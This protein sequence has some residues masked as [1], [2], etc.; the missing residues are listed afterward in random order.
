MSRYDD[1]TDDVIELLD[2]VREEWF[3]ELRSAKIKVMFDTKKRTSGGKVV[4]ARIQKTNDL[5]K[6]L[7]KEEVMSDFGYDYFL[8]LDKM[9][10]T[11]GTT[12]EDKKKILQHELLHTSVDMEKDNSYVV[13][14][15]EVETFYDEIDRCKDDPRWAE[16]L[17]EVGLSLYERAK[18]K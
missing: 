5:Q 17:V 4:I 12:D 9:I 10:W 2:K 18:E 15:H 13:R 16:R 11:Q 1:V 3:P 6:Y 7:T 8:Y 14:G